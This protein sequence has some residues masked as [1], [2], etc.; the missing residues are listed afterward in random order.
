MSRTRVRSRSERHPL[1]AAMTVTKAGHGDQPQ[2]AAAAAAETSAL[3]T[4]PAELPRS[5][6]WPYL[7]LLIPPTGIPAVRK[8]LASRRAAPAAVTTSRHGRWAPARTWTRRSPNRSA[9]AFLPSWVRVGLVIRSMTGLTSALAHDGDQLPAR[10]HPARGG[11]QQLT[12]P[13][14]QWTRRTRPAPGPG[15]TA[16]G[17]RS[18]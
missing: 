3:S 18:R 16:A 11:R 2:R 6:P 13:R 5:Q 10:V 7:A 4:R 15:S 14:P 12:G 1:S 8:H 9:G 17:Q